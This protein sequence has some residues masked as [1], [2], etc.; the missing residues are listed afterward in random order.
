VGASE[1]RIVRSFAPG[2]RGWISASWLAVLGAGSYA[3]QAAGGIAYVTPSRD[4]TE[5]H[6]IAPDGSQDERLWRVPVSV[7]REDGIGALSWSPDGTTIAFDS[8]HDWRRSLALRDIYTFR[9]SDGRLTRPMNAPHPAAYAG[10]PKGAVTVDI[11]NGPIGRKLDVYV[12]GAPEPKTVTMQSGSRLRLT[13]ENVADFGPNIPQYVRVFD[14]RVGSQMGEP[15]WFDVGGAAD[16]EPGKTVHA[17]EMNDRFD[18]NCPMLSSPAWRADG[19]R[20]FFLFREVRHSK[21]LFTAN[22]WQ[23]EADPPPGEAGKRLLEETAWTLDPPSIAAIAASPKR[24]TADHVLMLLANLADRVLTGDM[25]D[26]A[27]L[28]PLGL[29]VCFRC[30]ILG[31]APLPDGSGFLVSRFE[32]AQPLSRRTAAGVLYAVDTASGK[33]TELLRLPGEAIGRLAISPDGGQIVFERAPRLDTTNP[34]FY[35]PLFG[36]RLLCPCAL[37]IMGRDG[38]APKLLVQDGRAPAWRPSGQ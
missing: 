12:A 17:G 21:S 11:R 16:V 36:P 8:A 3:A 10:L 5:I 6:V 25:R 14:Y 7:V 28:K 1:S 22:I 29:D 2:C 26:P 20:L 13:F 23:V 33:K 15:C 37:W 35:A 18:A 30:H 38:S 27:A 4:N 9:P 24:E 19:A 34:R 31:A 32:E